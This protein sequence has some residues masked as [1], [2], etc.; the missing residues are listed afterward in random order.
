M[1][2]QMLGRRGGSGRSSSSSSV[3][4]TP[5]AAGQTGDPWTEPTEGISP[6]SSRTSA[7][8]IRMLA[9]GNMVIV[10]VERYY[11]FLLKR[12]PTVTWSWSAA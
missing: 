3:A 11:D 7:R 8:V 10:L 4:I 2:K 1:L 5:S 12:W 6:T 9:D